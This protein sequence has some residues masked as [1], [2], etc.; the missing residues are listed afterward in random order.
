MNATRS[1]RI[2][3]ENFPVDDEELA[4]VGKLATEAFQKSSFLDSE[5]A[6]IRSW[7][8]PIHHGVALDLLRCN[9]ERVRKRGRIGAVNNGHS[10]KRGARRAI[11]M[12]PAPDWYNDEY[13]QS[14]HWKA[15]RPT[16]LEFWGW[17]CSVCYSNIRELLEVHHRTYERRGRE[18]LTDC[19]V[20]C[21][22]CHEL[23]STCGRKPG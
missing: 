2:R 1:K 13:L 20:L 15:F 14:D 5:M 7:L 21:R 16:V 8:L 3:R 23:F 11:R 4:R 9:I 12:S 10:A 22:Q 17:R 6:E 19:I 18:R